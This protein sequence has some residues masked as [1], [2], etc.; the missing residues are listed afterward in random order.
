LQDQTSSMSISTKRKI[1]EAAVLLFNEN[2]L[3]NVRLQQIADEA[4]IS[5]GN[6]AYH[7]KNKEA[8]VTHVYETLFEEFSEILASYL[9]QPNLLDFNQ[10]LS[11]YFNF[12]HE[13]RFYLTDLFEVERSLPA[14]IEQW[15]QYVNKMMA[16]IR[17]RIDFNIQRGILIPE[18]SPKAYDLLANNIWMT[19]VFWT[20][21]QIL[22]GLPI[23]ECK[24]KEAV[25]SQLLP[26]FTPK[27]QTEY[28]T[29]ISPTTHI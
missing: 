18:P 29:T 19:I 5:V 21:Q 7:F 10:Q 25:W 13:Y 23:E 20:P 26:Y 11:K 3:A 22:R 8:I 14:V 15:H 16:Q 4:G 27:G 12:F 2:G 17:K 28:A 24:Y 1:F 9:L 6:L